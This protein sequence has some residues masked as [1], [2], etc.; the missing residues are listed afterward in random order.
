VTGRRLDG[1]SRLSHRWVDRG[2][3]I[4]FKSD[5]HTVEQIR[6]GATRGG[7]V[8]SNSI[9][10]DAHLSILSIRETQDLSRFLAPQRII[11]NQVGESFSFPLPCALIRPELR[12]V[13]TSLSQRA[14]I[15]VELKLSMFSFNSWNHRNQFRAIRYLTAPRNLNSTH[16]RN[17]T[18]LPTSHNK[19]D[20]SAENNRIMAPYQQRN[21]S[22]DKSPSGENILDKILEKVTNIDES[23]KRKDVHSTL[24]DSLIGIAKNERSLR[25]STVTIDMDERF[26][27]LA[28]T[29]LIDT[30]WMQRQSQ[31]PATYWRDQKSTYVQFQSP[32]TKNKFLDYVRLTSDFP[33]K[34]LIRR[35]NQEGEH[36]CRKPV[37]L[38]IPNVRLNIEASRILNTIRESISDQRI[39]ISEIR[40]GKKYAH[41]GAR[42]L[43]L[44]AN[45]A[46]FRHLFG[47]FNGTIPY[48][49]VSD[50]VRARLS[51]KLNCRPWMCKNC[52]RFDH[53]DCTGKL[54]AQCG[55]KDHASNHC[56]STT[57]YCSNCSK[58]GHR[59]RDLDCP[60]YINN[61]IRQLRKVDIPMEYFEEKELRYTLIKA[62]ILK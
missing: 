13:D 53:H 2:I 7:A 27:H 46:G 59:A 33:L 60:A 14:Y 30:H 8:A 26:D 32:I 54:C 19:S 16:Y 6:E 38:E 4:E 20:T 55:S 45:A 50:G 49:S 41:S 11:S 12:I 62:L 29:D 9:F 24:A 31:L 44:T 48:S 34:D 25:H 37:R 39:I 21:P 3:S 58:R 43:M 17:L 56:V 18:N 52:F 35:P 10:F 40:E 22:L 42:S 36:F 1:A 15:K 57:S 23:R 47:Y 61:M 28:I 51:L 5:C